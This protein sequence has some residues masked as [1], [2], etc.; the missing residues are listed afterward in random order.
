MNVIDATK[1]Y[2][3]WKGKRIPLVQADLE[4]KHEQMRLSAFAFLRSTFYRWAQTF[5][6]ICKALSE[7]PQI[8]S[9]GDLHVENFGT[10]RDAE[11]RLVWGVNDFDESA[12]MVYPND[13]VRLAASVRLAVDANH[14]KLDVSDACRAMTEAYREQLGSG[15][16]AYVLAEEHA[17]LRDLATTELRDPEAFWKRL[18]SLPVA[19]PP[20]LQ[21]AL[22]ALIRALPVGLESWEPRNRRAGLGSLGHP[23]FV[24]AARWEG[25]WIA[26]EAKAMAP[27][28]VFWCESERVPE[29][30]L[31]PTI[32]RNAVRS[33]DP[34]VALHGIWAVR[35]LAPDCSRIELSMLPKGRDEMRLVEAMARE[36]ANVHIGSKG[37]K[38]PVLHH[39]ERLSKHWL[40]DACEAMTDQTLKDFSA[41]KKG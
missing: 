4:F 12:D 23:R 16:A 13:L 2:E 21:S 30:I 22:T 39:L 25:G 3:K 38:E 14:L 20:P 41:F 27:S 5:P 18:S 11:G 32:T 17:W 6:K 9:V 34:F 7:A 35:R 1:D 24:A 36:V 19:N 37:R 26:R 10:W 28:S 8:L 33:H 40:M 31:M 15:G 29:E